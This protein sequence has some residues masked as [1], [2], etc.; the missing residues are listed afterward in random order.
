[1]G[2]KENLLVRAERLRPAI[3]RVDDPLARRALAI[4][5]E[6]FEEAATEEGRDTQQKPRLAHS[7]EI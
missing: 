6:A 4:L 7:D 2:T 1:M 3:S 5:I